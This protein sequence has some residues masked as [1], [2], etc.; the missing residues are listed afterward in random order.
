MKQVIFRLLGPPEISYNEEQIKIPRRRSRAL[1]YYMVSTHMPQPRER[2]LAL[3]CGEMDE[4]SARRTF[5]TLLA[6]VRSYLRTI[7]PNIEWIISDRDQ[8]TFNPLAPIWLDTA[9]FELDAGTFSR[10]L[11]PAIKLYRSDFLDGF[12]LKD[13]P[14]FDEWVRTTRDHFRQ[15]YLSALRQLATMYES[16]NQV[17]QAITCMQMLLSADPFSEEAYMHLMR[18]YW[19][20]GDRT[21]A[22]RQ[23][24]RLCNVLAEAFAVQPSSQTE[25]LY[26]EIAYSG[27]RQPAS[28]I[29]SSH[30]PPSTYRASTKVNASAPVPQISAEESDAVPFIGRSS[31]LKWFRECLSG[32]ASNR[33]LLLLQGEAGSG[34]TRLIQEVLQRYCS[35]WL[36]LRGSC[37]E[38]ERKN[39]YRVFAKALRQG[40][41]A[42]ELTH[43]Q[44]PG[45][46]L[47]QLSRLVPDLFRDGD[48]SQDVSSLDPTILG[49]ALV[50][51]C[52]QLAGPQQPV[53]VVLEDLQWADETTLGLVNHLAHSVRR[54]DVFVLA[55]CRTVREERLA[56]LV[57]STSR[58]DT[59]ALLEL[60]PLSLEETEELVTCF[61]SELPFDSVMEQTLSGESP[62]YWCYKRSEGNP[63][64]AIEW[65][66]LFKSTWEADPHAAVTLMP[67]ALEASITSE[68]L[69]L[70]QNARLLLSAGAYL[71]VSFPLLTVVNL[72]G[73]DPVTALSVCDELIDRAL[74]AEDTRSGVDCYTFQHASVREV[75]LASMG[76]AHRQLLQQLTHTVQPTLG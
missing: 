28:A 69:M 31:S 3:L 8:L 20:L 47:S 65:L 23:Y 59:L 9:I 73:F 53:L 26:Q 61:L 17:E 51:L 18:L 58:Q 76:T 40:L 57:R 2:L 19:M 37:Q 64:F 45:P 54:G 25:A 5:K 36:V 70:S 24:E 49:D 42:V 29:V 68:L 15:L 48:S 16:D 43:L 63:F 72:L 10:S 75:I 22:L 41:H 33:P 39:P 35:S 46:W 62:G 50:A 38:A 13:A 60:P 74:I 1:L 11:S 14:E 67:A 27:K 6:E 55:S 12:F 71:G 44:L 32:P 52:N 34:K 56:A 7:D 66:A 4:E 30:S 21:Q